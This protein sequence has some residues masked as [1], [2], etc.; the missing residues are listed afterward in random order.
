M[1]YV[2]LL[3]TNNVFSSASATVVA[4]LH[5]RLRTGWQSNFD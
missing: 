5:E 4:E 2:D 3:E 1:F